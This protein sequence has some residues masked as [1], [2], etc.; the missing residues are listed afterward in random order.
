VN[1]NRF[2]AAFDGPEAGWLT[3]ALE[4]PGQRYEFSPSHVPYDSVSL[5]ASGMLAVLEGREAVVPWNDEPAVHEFHLSGSASAVHLTVFA[6]H[7]RAHSQVERT[8]V[9]SLQ[10]TAD[11]VLLPLWRALRELQSRFSPEEYHRRWREPFPAAEVTELGRR[12]RTARSEH[13]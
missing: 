10:G 7:A 8:A 4:A 2:R 11:D 6:V 9:F 1:R 5:L 3:V 12:L 13:P